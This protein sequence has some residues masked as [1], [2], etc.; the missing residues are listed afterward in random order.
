MGNLAF[1]H[2]CSIMFALQMSLLD[3]LS[4]SLPI[5]SSI[6]GVA[7]A[8]GGYF[9]A[10]KNNKKLAEKERE[11]AEKILE[12]TLKINNLEQQHR[13]E[14]K[15]L[16]DK[17]KDRENDSAIWK[18]KYFQLLQDKDCDNNSP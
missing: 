11:M 3:L 6:I 9:M 15:N 12:N 16:Q 1:Q 8:L 18:E 10:A 14:L 17:I 7:F 5:L 13:T 2:I 4:S